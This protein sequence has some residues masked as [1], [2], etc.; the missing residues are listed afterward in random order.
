[1]KMNH[2][3]VAPGPRRTS[4]AGD[5]NVRWKRTQQRFDRILRRVLFVILIV[6]GAVVVSPGNLRADDLV[7][8]GILVREPSDNCV[9]LLSG[10][11]TYLLE[12]YGSF[13]VGDSVLVTARRWDSLDCNGCDCCDC[14]RENTIESSH[15]FD[16]G[17]GRLYVN[18]EYDCPFL[19]SDRFG[20]IRIA[21]Y[22]GF[23]S[24]DT[25][26][27]TGDFRFNC[28]AIAECAA[29]LCLSRNAITSCVT[30]TRS[31]T[32]GSI[33]AIFR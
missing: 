17:C 31:S 24:G 8:P 4:P 27:V 10:D 25:V 12:S 19:L 30:S 32:W 11:V 14:L 9:A 6:V 16:F 7:L 29:P 22:D 2:H 15:G 18:D 21:T 13:T 5:A 3:P 1:M 20:W 28:T 26:R 33:R 23:A